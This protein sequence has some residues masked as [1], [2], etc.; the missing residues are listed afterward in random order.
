ML[1]TKWPADS[2][3]S[4]ALGSVVSRCRR[5][6][7]APGTNIS[8]LSILAMELALVGIASLAN[9]VLFAKDLGA[10]WAMS[11]AAVFLPLLLPLRGIALAVFRVFRRSRQYAGATDVLII[12]ECVGAS[13][14]AWYVICRIWDF[15]IPMPTHVF[16]GDAAAAFLLLTGFHF[17]KRILKSLHALFV[18]R[19]LDAKRVVIVGAGDAGATVVRE[20]VEDPRRDMY[21]VA[22]ID[23]DPTKRGMLIRGVPVVGA[24]ADLRETIL[25]LHVSEVLVCIPSASHAQMDYILEAC[26]QCGVPVRTLPALSELVRR[27]VSSR[28][29]RPVRV[30]DLLPRKDISPDRSVSQALVQGK[31]VLVTG[32]GGSI[33][34]ELS[35]QIAAAAPRHLILLDKSENNLFLSHAVIQRACPTLKVTPVL[36]DILDEHVIDA[37]FAS[38]PPDLVFHAAAFKHVGMMELH[39]HQAIKN[40][41]LGTSRLLTAAAMHGVASFVNIS[42]DKAVNP[43]NYMGVSKRLAEELVRDTAV[44]HRLRFMNVRF[45]NV[46]G[47]SGSVLQLFYEQ[48]GRGG[49]LRITDPQASRYFM[50][51]SEAVYLVLC[52]ASLGHGGETFIF[53]M[54]K[55]INI[56][57]LARTVS[58]FSGLAP[59]EEMPIEFVGLR[60]GE[61]VHEELWELWEQPQ[62]TQH[63]QI[64]ALVGAAPRSRDINMI[65]SKLGELLNAHDHEGLVEYLKELAP[66][67]TLQLTPMPLQYEPGIITV[68]ESRP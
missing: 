16:W 29:L 42:T 60:D 6:L 59:E 5:S 48:L 33:G 53:D 9:L 58:L 18:G 52:A 41:V 10:P 14:F 22:I 46:A 67:M 4:S 25:R 20:F 51:I 36:A 34:S 37:L 35:K 24:V 3:S 19:A 54:G 32:A 65:V 57:E 63:T 55:P 47:S 45:G 62:P 50:S 17:G 28:D 26:R 23:D 21:P 30:E 27:S 1:S 39:P 38:E 15:G 8:A 49:P 40:N 68:Q 43:C 31:T 11:A 44:R 64:L 12:A 61:K 7:T 56:Y 2:V 66:N 13:S